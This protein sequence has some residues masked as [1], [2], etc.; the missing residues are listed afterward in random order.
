MRNSIT[1]LVAAVSLFAFAGAANASVIFTLGNNPQTGEQN[2]LFGSS[3][4]GTTITGATNQSNTPVQFTSSQSLT[5]GGVGQAFFSPTDSAA[6]LTNFTFTVPGFTFGDFIFNPAVVGQPQGG[7]GTATVT[8]VANDGTFVF[9]YNLG[10]GNNFLTITTANGETLS[11]V[12]VSDPV[13]F[14]QLQQPRVSTISV[15]VPEPATLALLGLGL[16]GLGLAR[17]SRAS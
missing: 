15:P 9:T 5:T 13:G 17:R 3:Q 16:V 12:S 14:N 11:S 1:G 8:A 10:S 6:L 4:T 2:I 7:G